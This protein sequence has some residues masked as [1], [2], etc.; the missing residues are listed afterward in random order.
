V[1][2]GRPLTDDDRY[3]LLHGPYAAPRCRPGKRLMCG[4]R[5]AV[6]VC[7][8]SAGRIPWPVGK[9]GRAKALIVFGGLARAVRTESNQAVCHWWGVTPQT[10]S[11]WR[12]LLGVPRANEGTDRLYRDYAPERLPPEVQE[13]ARARANSPEA[14]AKKGTAWKGKP[15]PPHV[16]A[17]LDRTGKR[18][19]DAA[20]AKMRAEHRRR[21]QLVMKNR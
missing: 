2:L 1:T 6:I 18:H 9:R 15:R 10:V 3:R 16:R 19:T 12:R 11:R 20:R 7:G 4:V 13:R 5:G 8:L 14:N 17:L 21:R